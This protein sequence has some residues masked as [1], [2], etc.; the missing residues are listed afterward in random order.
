MLTIESLLK[1]VLDN[2]IGNRM[3]MLRVIY[4]D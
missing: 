1:I 4:K 3:K 2:E